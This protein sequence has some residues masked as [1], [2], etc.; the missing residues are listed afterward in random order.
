MEAATKH[1]QG[2]IFDF[3]GTLI[4]DD[5]LHYQAW[6]G[7]SKKRG[8]DMTKE[9]F[10]KENGAPSKHFV[11]YVYQKLNKTFSEDPSVK[12]REMQEQ[13]QIKDDIYKASLRASGIDLIEGARDLFQLLKDRHIPFTIATSSGKE[14][15]DLYYEL[16]HLDQYVDRQ[17]VCYSDGSIKRGKP[18]PDIFIKAAEKLK[19]DIKK[20]IVF[21]DSINGVLAGDSAGAK[22]IEIAA[23]DDEIINEKK[24]GIQKLNKVVKVLQNYKGITIDDLDNCFE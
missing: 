20:C 7:Y 13:I 15:V 16:F 14:E 17:L 23:S 21:E 1:L 12:D 18:A 6:A 10:Q 8:Y 4:N 24:K 19:V 9:D 3:N 22:V 2:V 11:A 5:H